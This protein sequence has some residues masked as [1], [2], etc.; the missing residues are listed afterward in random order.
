MTTAA[1]IAAGIVLIPATAYAAD[2]ATTGRISPPTGTTSTVPSATSDAKG[3]NSPASKSVRARKPLA[4]A[5]HGSVK[6]LATTATGNTIYAKASFACTGTGSGTQADPYCSVQT[7]VNA[8]QYGD[9]VDVIGASGYFAEESVT[10]STS[11]ITIVGSGGT[12]WINPVNGNTA[13][14]LILNHVSGVTVRNVMLTSSVQ[15]TVQVLGSSN[16]TLDS[17]YIGQSAQAAVNTLSIDGSSSNVTVSRSYLDTDGFKNGAQAIGVAAGASNITLAGNLIAASGI[18]ATGV[19]GLN[20]AGNTI[21]RGCTAGIDVE[22]SSTGVA[23]ENNLLEDANPTTDVSLG[24]YQQACT[25]AS[26]AWAPDITVAS[27]SSSATTADYN[28]FYVYSADATAPYSWAGVSYASLGAFET[29]TGQG[30]HDLS[31]S[32]EAKVLNPDPGRTGGLDATLTADSSAVG[33]ANTSAPGQLSTDYYGSSPY[34]SRGAVQFMTANPTL[35]VAIGATPT[36]AYG[37]DLEQDITSASVPL[38][39]NVD[40]GDGITGTTTT[41]GAQT[42]D[43][44]HTYAAIGS[45]TVTVTVTDNSSD[46]VS[47]AIIATTDGS[48]YTPYGPVRI[49]DTRFAIGAPKAQLTSAN[50]IKLKVDGVGKIPTYA[51]A[52][53]LNLTLTNATGGGNVAAFPDGS[54]EQTSNLNYAAGQTVANLAIVPIGPDGYIDLAKQ[55]PG[56]VDMIADVEGFFTQTS[57]SGYTA[58]ASPTRIL[59]T[60]YAIGAPKKPLN[61]TNPIKLKVAGAG[62]V[63]TGVT[64]VSLNLTLTN[65]GGGGDVI[66]YPDGTDQ[67][68]ASNINYTA[69]QTIA[70]AA[71]VPVGKDGYIDLVKQGGGNVDAIADVEGYFTVGATGAYE[72]VD[73]QRLFDSR[74]PTTPGKLPAQFYYSLALDQGKDGQGFPGITTLILN[75]TVTNVTGTGFVTVFPDN[76]DG[77]NGSALVPNASNLN[78]DKGGTVPNL[79]FAIPDPT[80]VID[81]YNG[82]TASSLDLIVDIF[83]Y[84]QQPIS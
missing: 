25:S 46:S 68:T 84:F 30:G 63:P 13:P 3:V 50:P 76:A 24:G 29:A 8:A 34:T 21:Q 22:G 28:D 73:P 12:P 33:S 18:Q 61:S 74:D 62:G 39:V 2:P 58:G 36:S 56:A 23:I 52:V 4:T 38:T 59:D 6:S 78:F 77:T 17:D 15:G 79:T 45:Y 14:A 51:T 10:V 49:L 55:G 9:T 41:T 82:A 66:A 37:I 7:A 32:A 64:A 60:R 54:T 81:F 67:P 72:P 47:N 80:G 53:T 27:G 16:I 35:S 26:L 42:L 40:W 31:D 43:T 48:D 11:N 70:N 1:S 65:T 75:T 69:G 19:S 83:G 5:A 57:S 71:I 44:D 20:I